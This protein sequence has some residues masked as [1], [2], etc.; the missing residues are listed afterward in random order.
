MTERKDRR[1]RVEDRRRRDARGGGP[2]SQAATPGAP[3]PTEPE[4]PERGAR[5][6]DAAELEALRAEL[7]SLRSELDAARA[8][9][10]AWKAR[11]AELDNIRKKTIERQGDLV[12]R[13]NQ[14]LVEKLL[15][16]LD[17]LERAV[18]HG[19]GGPGVKL[20]LKELEGVLGAHGLEKVEALGRPFD[21]SVHHAVEVRPSDEVEADSVIEVYEEGYRFKDRVVRP[22][23]VVVAHPSDAGEGAKRGPEEDGE[24]DSD[25]AAEG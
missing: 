11:A 18:A 9:V 1:I 15:P 24:P 10:D 4:A 5:E 23:M 13:A 22:A 16:V 8:E 12:A 20:V 21:P 17:N 19:E 3:A 6:P 7:D 14:D 25:D 2:G